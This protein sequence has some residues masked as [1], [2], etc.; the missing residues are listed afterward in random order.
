MWLF[1]FSIVLA[2]ETALS[3][4][5]DLLFF[6]KDGFDIFNALKVSTMLLIAA[7]NLTQL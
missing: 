3:L 7:D 4:P 6:G 1:I 5:I 2:L